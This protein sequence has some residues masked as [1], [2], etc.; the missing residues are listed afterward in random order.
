MDMAKYKQTETGKIPEDHG[1][2]TVSNETESANTG[3]DATK[4]APIVS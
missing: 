4:R 1:L 3:L 2:L